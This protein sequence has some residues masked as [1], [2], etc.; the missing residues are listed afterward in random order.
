MQTGFAFLEAGAVSI[1]ATI[2]TLFKN[3]LDV[4]VGSVAFLAFGTLPAVLS[5]STNTLTPRS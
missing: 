3:V 5:S 1:K 4:S 2:A